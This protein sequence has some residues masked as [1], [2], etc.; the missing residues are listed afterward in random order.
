MFETYF[1]IYEACVKSFLDI[2]NLT[3]QSI[4]CVYLNSY[5]VFEADDVNM[6]QAF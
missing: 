1:N 4:C 5:R 2:S 3:V 6:G